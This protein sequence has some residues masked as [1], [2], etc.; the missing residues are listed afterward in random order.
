[1]KELSKHT[2][3]EDPA[4]YFQN[5]YEKVFRFQLIITSNREYTS[6]QKYNREI[7][8]VTRAG[9]SIEPLV[10]SPV[11]VYQFSTETIDLINYKEYSSIFAPTSLQT[12]AINDNGINYGTD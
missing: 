4:I 5:Q 1:M 10:N 3:L 8:K 6:V 7:L 2:K 11:D 12:P 9:L